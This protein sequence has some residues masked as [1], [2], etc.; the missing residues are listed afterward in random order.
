MEVLTLLVR[1]FLG[2]VF[3]MAAWAKL[4]T[5]G[6]R[7]VVSD[8]GIWSMGFSRWVAKLI[9]PIELAVAA[10]L[11]VVEVPGLLAAGLLFVTFGH[12]QALALSLGYRGSCGCSSDA[13]RVSVLGVMRSYTWGLLALWLASSR[14]A[15]G[16]GAAAVLL[17]GSMVAL[18]LG[19]AATPVLAPG[20]RLRRFRV[21]R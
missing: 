4:S 17:A 19:F 3:V 16:P 5:V 6:R 10:A 7:S 9:A 20:P 13:G 1:L 8:Y 21:F 18:L 2:T 15:L 14:L 11:V 12:I